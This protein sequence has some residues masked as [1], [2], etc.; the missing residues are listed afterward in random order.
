[1]AAGDRSSS[2]LMSEE[3][4]YRAQR[5][6]EGTVIAEVVGDHDTICGVVKMIWGELPDSLEK[7]AETPDE[8]GEWKFHLGGADWLIVVR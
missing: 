4:R 7:D 5:H 8:K 6:Q 2:S 1:M 3:V